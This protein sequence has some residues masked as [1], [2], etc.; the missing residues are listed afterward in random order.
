MALAG[1]GDLAWAL[2][3]AL[4]AVVRMLWDLRW[5]KAWSRCHRRASA[6]RDETTAVDPAVSLVVCAH[7]DLPALKRLWPAWR[8]QSFPEGW[9][10]QWIAVDDGSAD[11]TGEWL[12]EQALHDAS[13]TVVHHHKTRPGKKDALSAGIA[14][15]AHDR[16]VLT[17]ADCLPGPDWAHHL[18]AGLGNAQSEPALCFGASLPV[19]GPKLLHFD[20]LRIAWQSMSEAALGRPYMAVGRSLAYRKTTWE[21]LGG[22]TPHRDLPSGDD[23]LFVQQ[24]IAAGRSAT[25]LPT[26]DPQ[27]AN[28]T[29]P[30]N[31]LRDGLHRKRRHLSTAPRYAAATKRRL[32]LDAGLDLGVATA[33]IAGAFLLHN[34]GWIP[35]V[36]AGAALLVRA[37]TLSA[38]AKDQG[39]PA[40]AGFSAIVWGPLRWGFLAWATLSNFT[41]SP[42]WTQRA[43]T[44]RS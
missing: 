31:S 1:S 11:G 23:D 41:S 14:A 33:G 2:A 38:F 30:A 27:C 39:L 35:F 32:A 5:A 18:A 29:A 13:L 42:T 6:K 24:V 16:L 34:G 8:G 3:G 21:A 17:D 20:A 12:R 19:G 25:P 36:A 37:T 10:V 40:S 26:P 44:R 4:P 7:N 15:A 43:P 9:S 22:F 28:P